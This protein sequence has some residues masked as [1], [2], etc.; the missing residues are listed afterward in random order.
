MDWVALSV[1][2]GSALL[3][4]GITYGA[5]TGRVRAL[6]RDVERM[7]VEKASKESVDGLKGHLEKIE[8]LL[9]DLR[10]DLIEHR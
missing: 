6:E 9:E 5:L 7:H 2:V 4:G 1:A 10:R 8:K 3:S